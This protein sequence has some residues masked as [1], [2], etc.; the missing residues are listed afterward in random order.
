MLLPKICKRI[1]RKKTST[2]ILLVLFH[3]IVVSQEQY[4]NSFDNHVCNHKL[5]VPQYILILNSKNEGLLYHFQKIF[6]RNNGDT[7][8]LCFC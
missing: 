4:M 1:A 2:A 3:V 5:R 6:F 8:I 7:Q